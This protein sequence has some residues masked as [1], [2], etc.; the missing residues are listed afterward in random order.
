MCIVN[1]NTEFLALALG[2]KYNR[3]GNSCYASG[4]RFGPQHCCFGSV[5]RDSSFYG[6]TF[7]VSY[8]TFL[9]F[10]NHTQVCHLGL[11]FRLYGKDDPLIQG[12]SPCSCHVTNST[13]LIQLIAKELQH[14]INW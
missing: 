9:S 11:G 10:E 4:R 8:G 13:N 6:Q 7:D 5:D 3:S 14:S 1:Y 2:I 12:Y